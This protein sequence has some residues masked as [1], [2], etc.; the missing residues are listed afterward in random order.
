MA[1][2]ATHGWRG[3]SCLVTGGASGIGAELVR[4]LA[5]SEA[6]VLVADV[7]SDAAAALADD[8]ECE[9]L[10]VDVRDPE[11]AVRMVERAEELYGR[12]DAAFL[13]AGVVA[14]FRAWDD[15]DVDAYR[16]ISGVNID[17]VVF[18][19]RACL[20]ALRRA[21]GGEI[22]VTASLAGLVPTPTTPIYSL[23]KHAV[24]GLVRSL[25]PPLRKEGITIAAVCPGFTRTPLLDRVADEFSLSDLPLL[26]AEEVA[27]VALKA[28]Q[29]DA[30]G[31]C[32]VCQPGREPLTYSFRGV[33]G[34]K[35]PA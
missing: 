12:L 33:P 31:E 29:S 25:G 7:D 20:P 22:V 32:L 8:T 3:R 18:G 34:P 21:G 26:T 2:V 11:D 15:F 1:G 4:Q 28:A 19:I 23:T 16:L 24:V 13:N 17:G 5:A 10:R 6:R 35:A 30:A 27:A 9:F 14:D